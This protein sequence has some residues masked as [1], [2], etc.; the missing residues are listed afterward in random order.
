MNYVGAGAIGSIIG[1]YIG[2]KELLGIQS[3][4]GSGE[5]E[6][7]QGTETPEES[8]TPGETQTPDDTEPS[9]GAEKRISFERASAG[10]A[11][12]ADP[13]SVVNDPYPNSNSVEISDQHAT[14]RSQ[15]LHMSAFGSL[16]NLLVGVSA[17][18][19][20]VA[21]VL[22]DVYIERSNHY[23]GFMNFGSW[24][25]DEVNRAIGF[26]G[27]TGGGASND[28][29]GEFTDLEGDI[30]EW[31]GEHLLVFNVQGDN[32]AYFD[33]LRFLDANGDPVPVSELN[34][35]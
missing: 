21:T 29:T 1:Y 35:S 8:G 10:A 11:E 30:S 13:W 15:T 3:E 28:V 24:D 25:G 9:G 2:A 18:V 20:G 32:E 17:D 6:Q 23:N 7:P 4:T 31:T 27:Q 16:E 14:H 34:L 33:N 5:T 26:Q 22:C 12:P 19:S